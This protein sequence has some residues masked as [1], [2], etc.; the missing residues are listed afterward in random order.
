M[1]MAAP[2]MKDVFP[3]V[4]PGQGFRSGRFRSLHV[5]ETGHGTCGRDGL[6]RQPVGCE[7]GLH[8]RGYRR[9][10]RLPSDGDHRRAAAAERAAE[11]ASRACCTHH[12]RI[13]RNQPLAGD[14]EA[15]AAKIRWGFEQ[16]D[17]RETIGARGRKRIADRWSW[18][19]TAI[20]TV[21]QYRI[22]LGQ[23]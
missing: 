13:P 20:K 15:L 11:R 18:T 2:M 22:R 8:C 9:S 3:T 19:H 5:L 12:R 4:A 21:E 14:S 7:G 10:V 23:D 6:R 17:L 1:N 16:P